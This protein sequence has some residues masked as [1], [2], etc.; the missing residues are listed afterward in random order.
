MIYNQFELELIKK[1]GI[2]IHQL[3]DIVMG[4]SKDQT[5]ILSAAGSD[6]LELVMLGRD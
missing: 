1:Y 5:M 3:D 2:K 4:L 6:L